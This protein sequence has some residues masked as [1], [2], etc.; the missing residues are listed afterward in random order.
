MYTHI[1]CLATDHITLTCETQI[2]ASINYSD[3]HREV[4]AQRC[5]KNK[6]NLTEET[7]LSIFISIQVN[8]HFV[9]FRLS[10]HYHFFLFVLGESPF[11]EINSY[12]IH[13]VSKWRDL[14]PKFILQTYRDALSSTGVMDYNFVNDMYEVCH[15]VM[16][17]TIE[18]A[19]DKNGLIV[20]GGTPDQT[21]DAWVM[22]GVR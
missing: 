10:I 2:I 4:K 3:H 21:F 14:N 11:T 12:N 15:R 20:N 13:D 17:K 5:L 8:R 16:V 18:N 7:K 19:V 9:Q 6:F 1:K 22:T